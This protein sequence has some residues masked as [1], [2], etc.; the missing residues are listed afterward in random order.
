MA[1]YSDFTR[2]RIGF[3]FGLS[4][5]QLAVV[6]AGMLP[7]VWAVHRGAWRPA[8]V[9]AAAWV[10][11]VVVVVVPV[12]GRSMAGWTGAMV[13]FAVGQL[14]GWSRFRSRAATGRS[15]ELADPD[16]PGALAGVMIHDGPPQGPA[17]TRVAFIQDHPTR[18]WAVSAAV[19]HPGI[20]LGDGAGRAWRV[21]GLRGC[22]DLS[23]M[24]VLVEAVLVVVRTVPDDGAGRAAWIARHRL[25]QPRTAPARAIND[26][27]H[28]AL[29]R[30]VV[31]TEAF[32]T[33]VVP[34]RRLARQA[35][36]SGGGLRGRGAVLAG[37][38]AE[39]GAHLSGAVG[40]TS[41]S[42]M[43]SADLA[44]A[45]RTAFAPGDRAALVDARA[46]AETTSVGDEAAAATQVD[47]AAAGPSQALPGVR[48]YRHD[49]WT[50]V[51][52]TL[53]L[54]PQ[55]AALGALSPILASGEPGERRSLLIAY[56]ILS[57]KAADKHTRSTEWN[58]DLGEELRR[59]AKVRQRSRER[60]ETEKVRRLD[61]KVAA[62]SALV[63]PY[64]VATITGPDAVPAAEYGRRLDTAIRRAGF[65]PQRLDIAHDL[66]FAASTMPLGVGLTRRG[67]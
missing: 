61:R 45:C 58:A 13:A 40:M 19:T 6:A 29:T 55:G 15:G 46:A 22:L 18:T 8:G 1:I 67:D 16:V 38:A 35:R 57:R 26:E 54:P 34:D 44:A 59:R 50:S 10:V 43:S 21:F 30:A 48:S 12:R 31:R 7:P 25:V 27:L 62:G 9:L 33:V 41:V 53:I 32:V 60:L 66:A 52:S 51:S 24:T 4:G 56:P 14:A 37:L 23:E 47:W 17:L 2:S 36:G 3:F 42:W 5:W 20:W 49:G 28:T 11:V 65:T 64:A 63:R 39:I